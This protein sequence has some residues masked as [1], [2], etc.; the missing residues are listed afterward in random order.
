MSQSAEKSQPP[1]VGIE[2]GPQDVKANILPHLCK[3]W[4]L[5]QDSRSVLNAYSYYT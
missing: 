5:P 4:L 2:P 3:S 1:E